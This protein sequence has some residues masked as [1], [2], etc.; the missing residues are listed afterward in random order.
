MFL[1][2]CD[3]DVVIMCDDGDGDGAIDPIVDRR[4]LVFRRCVMNK[5]IVR[6]NRLLIF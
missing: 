5:P 3:R 6:L 1:T 2:W 4:C